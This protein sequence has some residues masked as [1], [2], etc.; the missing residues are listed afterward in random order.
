MLQILNDLISITYANG[1]LVLQCSYVK[2]VELSPSLSE[3]CLYFSVLKK[4]WKKI[5]CQLELISLQSDY[6]CPIS[7]GIVNLGCELT[8]LFCF[9]FFQ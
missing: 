3:P 8:K 5:C 4:Y 6:V 2:C 7:S 1:V 9:A